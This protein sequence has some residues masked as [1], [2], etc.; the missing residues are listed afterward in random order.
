MK[1]FGATSYI[2]TM[3]NTVVYDLR[4][5]LLF[6][7]ILIILFAM[8]YAV[9]GVGNS[10]VGAY[11]AYIDSLPVNHNESLPNSEYEMI[12]LFFGYIL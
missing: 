12:G 5:F 10:K 7:V 4:I 8:I 2:V 1:I 9:L 3:I 11:G 6:Y